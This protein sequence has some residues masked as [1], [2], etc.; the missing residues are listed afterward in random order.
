MSLFS[1]THPNPSS[2]FP[3]TAPLFRI[4]FLEKKKY[5]NNLYYMHM[6]VQMCGG[7]GSSKKYQTLFY[8]FKIYSY[9]MTTGVV[10]Q[11]RIFFQGGT[12]L[13]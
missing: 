1:S 10:P 9:R 11:R 6:H 5:P 12:R 13:F 2:T 3:F 8:I 7:G 4:I